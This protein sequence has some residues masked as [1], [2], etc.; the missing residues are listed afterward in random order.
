MGTSYLRLSRP[1]DAVKAYQRAL[2]LSGGDNFEA[3]L[4]LAESRFILDPESLSGSVGT[5]IEALL[6]AQ[7]KH[8]KGLWYGGWVSFA[9]G[10]PH[11]LGRVGRRSLPSRRPPRPGNHRNPAGSAGG[12]GAGGR[13]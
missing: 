7:P 13:A 2:D 6:A 10:N 11:R 1:V 12:Q 9:R 5:E 3:R 8:P 4:G